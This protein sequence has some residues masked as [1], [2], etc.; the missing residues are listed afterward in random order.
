[1]SGILLTIVLTVL[2]TAENLFC[3]W[4]FSTRWSWKEGQVMFIVMQS[5]IIAG[6]TAMILTTIWNGG[7][8]GE[9]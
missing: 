3:W 4:R 9:K 7:G 5:V 2:F 1:M 6:T 8:M